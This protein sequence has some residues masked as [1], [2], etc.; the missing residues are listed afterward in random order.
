MDII[1]LI[2]FYLNKTDDVHLGRNIFLN[3]LNIVMYGAILVILIIMSV[4][5][6]NFKNSNKN[7]LVQPHN[8]RHWGRLVKN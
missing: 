3:K 7:P 1:S 5:Q 8:V 4:D 2:R 6:L